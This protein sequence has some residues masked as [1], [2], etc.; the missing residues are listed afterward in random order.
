MLFDIKLWPQPM[1]TIFLYCDNEATISR[2]YS[3]IYN[4]KSRHISIRHGY[5][6]E[7]I[8]NGVIII[9][10]VKFV[11]NLADSLMKGLSRDMVWKTTNRMG[12]KLVIKDTSNRN[13]TSDQ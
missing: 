7:L 4:A 9:I 6:R 13:P 5:I 11:N 10:Y 3:N 8:T 1:S 12:L 2:A